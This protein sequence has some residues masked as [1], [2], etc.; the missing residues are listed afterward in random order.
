M[1][2]G[3][4]NPFR[5]LT[6][7]ACHPARLS[8]WE[9]GPRSGIMADVARRR[10]WFAL[11]AVALVAAC[12][13][14][15]H[16]TDWPTRCDEDPRAPGCS[17]SS[18][19]L[20]NTGAGGAGGAG[21]GASG[22]GGQGGSGPPTFE[23]SCT[24]FAETG[25][26]AVEQCMPLVF[27]TMLGGDLGCP[28]RARVWGLTGRSGPGL[29]TTPAFGAVGVAAVGSATASCSDVIRYVLGQWSP[30]VCRV[31]GTRAD[32]EP[33]ADG[34]QC[35]GGGCQVLAGE[36]CGTC[37]TLAAEGGVCTL[38]TDCAAG[39]TCTNGACTPLLDLGSTCT[40]TADC[41]ADLFCSGGTCALR[42]ALGQPCDL[43][44]PTCATDLQCTT[45]NSSCELVP[46][47]AADAACGAVGGQNV[48]CDSGLYCQLA[49]P[50]DPAGTCV[51]QVAEGAVCPTNAFLFGAGPC[52]FPSSCLMGT[53]TAIAG[54][55]C[56]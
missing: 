8:P 9:A 27:A 31:P 30:A 12:G 10:G 41:Y 16:S 49:A 47:V 46:L 42:A 33:C 13:D 25:C 20:T 51:A 1:A 53:C 6:K 26:A 45:Q 48:A 52:P 36:T 2:S 11:L 15:F 43:A 35:S 37:F 5:P 56:P 29:A 18:S 7:K 38:P 3:A 55:A 23:A 21:G 24:T 28:G 50:G 44:S 4:A 19:T 14:L 22:G 17:T 54:A 32:G 34:R 40:T 39:L